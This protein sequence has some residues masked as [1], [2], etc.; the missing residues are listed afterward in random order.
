[1]E[2]AS[3]SW[4]LIATQSVDR[5]R[6]CRRRVGHLGWPLVAR[7]ERGIKDRFDPVELAPLIAEVGGEQQDG[8]E[9]E[10]EQSSDASRQDVRKLRRCDDLIA[11]A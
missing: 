3:R 2:S 10:K 8:T 4:G 11:G 6:S 1:M 5:V 9:T 7:A